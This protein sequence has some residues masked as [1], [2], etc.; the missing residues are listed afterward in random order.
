[1]APFP[2]RASSLL[3]LLVTSLALS[4]AIT[5]ARAAT[6][7]PLVQKQVKELPDGARVVVLP[8][9]NDGDAPEEPHFEDSYHV[10][11]GQLVRDE[12]NTDPENFLP[13]SKEEFR[14]VTQNIVDE[15]IKAHGAVKD[16]INEL[17]LDSGIEIAE[18]E[19]LPDGPAGPPE[20]PALK[21]GGRG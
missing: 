14:P 18:P 7:P 9:V 15:M 20:P 21:I 5:I 13:V 11:D 4:H 16:A 17:S 3:T 2:N 8:A 6:P 19:S 12:A 10:V 1:M